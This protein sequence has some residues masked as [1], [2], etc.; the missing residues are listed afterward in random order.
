MAV[1]AVEPEPK[2]DDEL[3]AWIQRLMANPPQNS[4]IVTFT[5]A[6]ADWI[7]ENLNIGN[8]PHKP[9]RIRQYVEDMSSNRWGLTGDTVKFSDAQKLRDGQNRMEACA[10]AEVPFTTHVVFGIDDK[11]FDIMDRGKNR[12]S[13]DILAIAGVPQHGTT[14]QAISWAEKLATDPKSRATMEPKEALERWKAKYERTNMAHW[15]SRARD[16]AKANTTKHPPGLTAA[17]LW[18]IAQKHD[19]TQAEGFASAWERG[20]KRGPVPTLNRDLKALH[21]AT[22]GRIH[23]TVRAAWVVQTWNNHYRGRTTALSW[24]P[25][26]DFPKML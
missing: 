22:G 4:R 8:R 5:P 2:T 16:I 11:L 1:Q 20:G 7:L 21:Q 25:K 24:Q 17:V 14:A 26:D 10:T 19:T 18:H 6:V 15:V 9:G 23:D 12:N 13:A 3:I